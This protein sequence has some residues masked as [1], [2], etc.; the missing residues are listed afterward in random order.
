MVHVRGPRGGKGL[1][2]ERG[3]QA[4]SYTHLNVVGVIL[5]H[6]LGK[7]LIA[8]HILQQLRDR[9]QWLEIV[10]PLRRRRLLR[11]RDQSCD[12]KD[13]KQE[14]SSHVA[15][16][17]FGLCLAMA[18]REIDQRLLFHLMRLR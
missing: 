13:G 18:E 15:D 17:T 10:L 4:V 8:F 9:R 2:V 3:V 7:L 11:M 1:C 16:D 6:G 14:D 5:T 12:A